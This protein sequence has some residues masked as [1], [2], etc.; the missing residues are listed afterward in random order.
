[1]KNTF[2]D[3]KITGLPSVILSIIVLIVVTDAL[4][5]T[6]IMINLVRSFSNTF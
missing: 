4:G 6:D 1:M 3:S 5:L 2:K